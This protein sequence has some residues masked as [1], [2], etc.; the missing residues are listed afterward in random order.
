MSETQERPIGVAV[1]GMGNVGAEVVRILT[2][3]ADDLQ[4]RVGAP[5]LLRGVSVRGASSSCRMLHAQPAVRC[6]TQSVPCPGGPV[7]R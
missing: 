6:T 4:A 2:E 5:V 3:N 1:L 7:R